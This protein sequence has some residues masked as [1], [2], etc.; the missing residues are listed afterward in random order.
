MSVEVIMRKLHHR[1]DFLKRTE[2]AV[3][4]T[5]IKKR[6]EHRV[7]EWKKLYTGGLYLMQKLQTK[8]KET[9]HGRL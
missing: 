6:E 9:G 5:Y 8:L 4:N 3:V 2:M 7:T 1:L